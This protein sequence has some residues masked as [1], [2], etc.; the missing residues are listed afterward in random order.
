MY[1][2]HT[3]LFRSSLF[4]HP[5]RYQ[6]NPEHLSKQAC[7][8]AAYVNCYR[9]HAHY[10]ANLDPLNLYN[11]YFTPYPARRLSFIGPLIYR[12]LIRTT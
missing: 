3:P 8:L 1:L 6:F 11:R 7:R 2:K 12:S 9:H 10:F 4:Y 5:C